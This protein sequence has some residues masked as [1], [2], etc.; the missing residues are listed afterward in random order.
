MKLSESNT[1][2]TK[3]P[4]IVTGS[5]IALGVGAL[6][7]LSCFPIMEVTDGCMCGYRRT[8][9]EMPESLLHR[10]KISIRTDKVGNAAH[11]H[12]L[13]D[14]QWGVWLKLPWQK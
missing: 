3:Q 9:Y 14:A 10:G 1:K 7:L 5:L 11:A 6:L 4:I 8:W 13:W 2:M 12:Q